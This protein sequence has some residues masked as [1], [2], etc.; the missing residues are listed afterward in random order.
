MSAGAIEHRYRYAFASEL[1][2]KDKGERLQLATSG[3]RSE[4]P[5][6]FQGQLKHPR[7]TAQL[8]RTLSKVVTSRFHIPAAMLQKILATRD[9]V[10]TSGGGLIRFEGFSACCSTYARV[11]VGPDGYDGV[12]VDQGTTNVDFNSGIRAALAQIRDTERVG[13]AVGTDE[14]ALLRGAEQI[15]ERKVKLPMRWLK[16]FVEVQAYQSRM[17][18]R[19]HFGKI[20]TLRFLRSLPRSTMAKT[21]YWVVPAGSG[22]RLSQ[23][24][25]GGGLRVAGIER[26]RLLDDLAP[27]ADGLS[28]FVDSRGDASEWQLH[29]GPLSFHLTISA[30]VWRGFSGEGQVLADLAAKERERLLTLVQGMLKWQAEIRPTEFVGNW[31]ASEENLRQAFA[32]LGSRG[33]VGYDVDRGAYFHRELP[34]D[35][36]L[37]E[38]VHPRLKNA[39]KLVE[40]QGV[41]ILRRT[42]ELIEA[43]VLGTDVTHRVRL[44]EAGDRCTC[45]WHAKHQGSRGPCKHILAVQ[46]VAEPEAISD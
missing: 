3:G 16:G 7:L 6:F 28:M 25:S 36:A 19:A 41:R 42:D 35:L 39:R 27:L 24:E 18:R 30:E 23:R 29:F 14:V 15:V 32:A 38:E 26:L 4:F 43:E 1:V 46:I 33:L 11:D 34:F 9:P 40:N 22:L 45:P 44:S 13:L 8:L 12:V 2:E 31:D 20:E 17:E 10:V 21:V 5:Y 37:V